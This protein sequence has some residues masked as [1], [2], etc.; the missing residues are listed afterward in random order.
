MG[1][2]LRV[3]SSWTRRTDATEACFE[4]E[5]PKIVIGRRA[6]VDVQLPHPAVSSTHATLVLEGPRASLV[7]EASTNGTKVNGARIA[8]QRAKP[9]RDGDVIEI[10][11]FTLHVELGIAATGVSAGDT[12]ALALQLL[13]DALDPD[14][15]RLSPPQL[16]VVNGTNEGATLVLPPAPSSVVLGRGDACDLQLPDAD[17]SREHATV[18]RDHRGVRVRDL[19]SKNGIAV[20]GKPVREAVLRDRDEVL[21]GATVVVFEDPAAGELDQ[22]VA[23]PEAQVTLPEPVLVAPSEPEPVAAPEPVAPKATLEVAEVGASVA[24]PIA[25]QRPAPARRASADL[26]VYALAAVVLALSAAGLVWLLGV[27]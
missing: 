5:Q 13:R 12:R 15:D 19:G 23:A 17:A 3:R 14:G 22:V 6:G 4:L 10:G 16:V 2:R 1:V 9:L 21:V 11:G 8:P 7:D 24:T 26:L 27:G 25:T 18:T 20:N